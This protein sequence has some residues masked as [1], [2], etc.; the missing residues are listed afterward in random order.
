MPNGSKLPTLKCEAPMKDIFL[1]RHAEAPYTSSIPDPNRPLST[2]GRQQAVDLAG[3]VQHF[4]IEEIHT[5]PYERCVHTI[6]PLSESLGVQPYKVHDL[7][8]REFTD[9][10]VEDWA[11]T[12]RTAWMDPDFSFRDGESGREAQS[13]MYI[14]VE[15]IIASSTA[16]TLAISSHG[17]VI[18]LLL[19]QIETT[20]TFEHAC[21]IRNPDVFRI[22]FDGI[23]I[24][25]D[26]NF[27]L[28]ALKDFSTSFGA[29]Q[30]VDC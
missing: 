10:H 1:I 4:G 3:L 6:A 14:A 23:R 26:R 27:T 17:N 12:W 24:R 5:S 30:E 8:E 21:A 20:Y 15:N 7:R 11:Q 13:R 29:D 25:W 19:Q 16:R 2:R 28:D 18:A 9:Y 22:T